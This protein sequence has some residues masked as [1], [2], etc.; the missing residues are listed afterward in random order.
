ML[1]AVSGYL[2]RAEVVALRAGCTSFRLGID[3]AALGGNWISAQKRVFGVCHGCRRIV[4]SN[5]ECSGCPLFFCV[6]CQEAGKSGGRCTVCVSWFCHDRC[7]QNTLS[8]VACGKCACAD[9]CRDVVGM[10]SEEGKCWCELCWLQSKEIYS[11]FE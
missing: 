1:G 4:P 7:R 11:P 10:T 2:T 8:C 3:H 5:T 6:P 9:D